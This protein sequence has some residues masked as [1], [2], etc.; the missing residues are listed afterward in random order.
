MRVII[1]YVLV[2]FI[3]LIYLLYR[4]DFTRE[5]YRDIDNFVANKDNRDIKKYKKNNSFKDYTEFVPTIYYI[6]LDGRKDRE[7]MLLD[8][9]NQYRFRN[10]IRFPA[11]KNK[12][13][14]YGCFQSHLKL[15]EF[16]DNLNNDSRE[17][18]NI[19]DNIMI[20]EDDGYFRV[21]DMTL[22]NLVTNF[23]K[24]IS[25][26]D[27]LM[28]VCNKRDDFHGEKV[29]DDIWRVYRARVCTCYIVNKEYISRL[30]NF[31]RIVSEYA[32]KYGWKN[33]FIIDQITWKLQEKD[34]WYAIYPFPAGVRPNYSDIENKNV[35]YDACFI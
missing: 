30:K 33:I 13:G 17:K 32:K 35:N 1:L 11:V 28:L 5:F 16:I 27:V 31:L 34:K 3:I 25:D 26:W 22:N 24:K 7:K 20:M 12:I 4:P 15:L 6:N 29:D 8:N 18:E 14:A 21:N 9:L 19:K 10:V 2:I 23:T